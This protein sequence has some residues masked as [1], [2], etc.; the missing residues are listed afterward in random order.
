[1]NRQK[2]ILLS[3]FTF[4]IILFSCNKETSTENQVP[5][6]PS[7]NQSITQE[8][9]TWVAV[10]QRIEQGSQKLYGE[11]KELETYFPN[12]KKEKLILLQEAIKNDD[13]IA[14][15]K[16]IPS[17]LDD[18]KNDKNV[19]KDVIQAL[20]Y[21]YISSMLNEGTYFYKEEKKAKQAIEYIDTVIL[22][23]PDFVDPFYSNYYLG[24]AQEIVKNY[25]SAL[26]YYNKALGFAGNVEKN[27][28]L[29][30]VI[31]NQIGHVHDLNWDLEQ[32]YKFYQ[33]SYTVFN[34]NPENILNLWRYFVRKNDLK[35]AKIYFEKALTFTQAKLLK[36]EIHYNLSS[37]YLYDNGNEKKLD[38]SLSN[39]QKAIEFNPKSP[40]GYLWKARVHI[41]QWTQLDEAEK[42]L[43][44]ALILHPNFSTAYE[45]LG[46]MEQW[47]WMY[48]KSI[49][50]F[51]KSLEVI[52][53]DII[54][55]NHEKN[56][57]I[58]RV[59]Y[60]LSISLALWKNK[61]MA[62]HHLQQMLVFKDDVSLS[63]FMSEIKKE[64]YWVFQE[65]K[66]MKDFEEIVSLLKK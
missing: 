48:S 43:K 21:H 16:V 57:N 62:I 64:N 5:Q 52:P 54:L 3:L 12:I 7:Q 19:D 1:M 14:A 18:I 31:L 47:K 8:T 40:L 41:L 2:L 9:A 50:Y 46:I 53:N 66:W 15:Q 51:L 26:E 28:K 27:K 49:E 61:E 55:M 17:I 23:D 44:Q 63:M 59:N 56:S 39:A 60:L 24:Y 20:Q 33:E 11:M 30:W 38:I 65:L 22:K 10:T 35:N 25:P 4:P 37:M 13:F 32:A 6:E 45:W 29:K 42:L 36:S 34:Q 58:A